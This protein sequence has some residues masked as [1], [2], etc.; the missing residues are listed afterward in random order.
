MALLISLGILIIGAVGYFS[1][2]R[3]SWAFYAFAHLGALGVMGIFGSIAGL[4]AKKKNR[5]YL[6]AFL[7]G[8]LLPFFCGVAAVLIF[9][10]GVDGRL[11]CGGSVSLA[12]AVLIV[13]GYVL[14]RKKTAVG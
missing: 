9:F 5:N 6:K 3:D 13:I 10:W 4:L 8:S 2:S 11:Y 12:A 1:L 7:L 14:S